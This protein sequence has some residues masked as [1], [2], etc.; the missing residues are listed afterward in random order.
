MS[1][2]QVLIQFRDQLIS[3]FDE[4]ITQFPEE[5]D[6]YVVRI[7]LKDQMPIKDIMDHFIFKLVTLREYVSKRD[8][9]FFLTNGAIFEKIGK[10]KVANFKKL[11][12]SG[13]LDDE[14][15]AVIWKWIDSFVFLA[16]KYQK[17]IEKQV[18][19]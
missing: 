4:L 14:D 13:R 19:K 3:F 10:D 1:E 16:D 11:W 8:E 15:K 5:P 7:F 17:E 6:L 18:K 2:T 12:R 9:Q